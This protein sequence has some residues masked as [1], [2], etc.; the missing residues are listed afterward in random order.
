[1]SSLVQSKPKIRDVFTDF[2]SLVSKIVL[3]V[4]ES[5]LQDYREPDWCFDLFYD[6]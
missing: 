4:F 1:M 2:F 5:S 3:I 6:V